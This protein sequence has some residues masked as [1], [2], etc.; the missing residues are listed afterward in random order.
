MTLRQRALEI[1]ITQ[2]GQKEK[3]IGS[4]WGHPVQDYLASVGIHFAASWCFAFVYWCFRQAA[5]ELNVINLC[6]KTGG[7][8]NAWRLGVKF[9]VIATPQPGDIFIMDLGHGLGHAGIVEEN[10][11]DGIHVNTIDGNTNDNGSREGIEVER[12]VRPKGKMLGYLRIVL[13]E[14]IV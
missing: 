5:E 12:K 10:G 13:P 14:E 9:R 7:V 2:I 8:L 11:S 6:P 3:P 1:A 4:N